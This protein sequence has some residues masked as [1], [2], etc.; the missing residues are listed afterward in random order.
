M[1]EASYLCVHPSQLFSKD[2]KMDIEKMFRELYLLT[3]NNIVIK[4][5]KPVKK[6]KKGTFN[7]IRL[8]GNFNKRFSIFKSLEF[9]INYH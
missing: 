4:I 1:A 3:N 7:H 2:E 9:K 6:V 5:L 8:S